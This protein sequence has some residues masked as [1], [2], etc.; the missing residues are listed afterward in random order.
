MAKNTNIS[1]SESI[2][3][4]DT[5]ILTIA[6]ACVGIIGFYQDVRF[7]WYLAIAFALFFLTIILIVVAIFL[8]IPVVK[9][10]VLSKKKRKRPNIQLRTAAL[11]IFVAGII[12]S[13]IAKTIETI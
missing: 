7:N 6:V 3:H 1:N 12:L 11:L 13:L 4:F 10:S 9:K 8:E 5:A 2:N